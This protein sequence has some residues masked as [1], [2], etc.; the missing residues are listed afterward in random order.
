MGVS[1]LEGG[2]PIVVDGK[3]IGGIGVSGRGIEG[4]RRDR[5]GRSGRREIAGRTKRY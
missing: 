2:V 1:L 3:I 5:D 4:R